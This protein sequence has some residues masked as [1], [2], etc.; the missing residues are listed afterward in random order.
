MGGAAASNH[1]EATMAGRSGGLN[2]ENAKQKDRP[3]VD[4]DQD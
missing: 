3:S 2:L 4:R 1:S